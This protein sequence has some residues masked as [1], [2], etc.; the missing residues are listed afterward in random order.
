MVNGVY[1]GREIE[2]VDGIRHLELD[3]PDHNWK[4]TIFKK[5]F[6]KDINMEHFHPS[7]ARKS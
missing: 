6:L 5:S 3:S 7:W 2:D 1:I 4:N